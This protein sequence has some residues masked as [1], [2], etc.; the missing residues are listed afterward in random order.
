[1]TASGTLRLYYGG[2]FD[3][4]HEGHL[5]IARAA[6]D[7]LHCPVRMMPAADPPHRAPPGADAVQRA[8]M[9]ALAI[10]NEDGLCVDRRELQ[11]DGPSYTVETLRGL[12]A[13]YGN[14]A[15]LALLIGADSLLGLPAWREWRALFELA[16]FVVADRPGNDLARLPVGE[17]AEAMDGRWTQAPADLQAAP[18]GRAYRLSQP[19]H[20]G[21]ATEVRARIAAGEPLHG[22][23]AD[24]VADYI[25]QHGLYGAPLH[26]LPTPPPL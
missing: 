14:A 18:A 7:A 6:R 15:P 5:A 26:G 16:H 4:V 2:T 21:S 17:L 1:M 9:L 13:A 23:V 19:L 12:R 11:R 10:G 24:A 8:E 3:P 22:W 20:P 25:R